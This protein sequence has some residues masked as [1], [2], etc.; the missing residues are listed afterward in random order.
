[1]GVL[2]W[3]LMNTWRTAV[4]KGETSNARLFS[5]VDMSVTELSRLRVVWLLGQCHT[6]KG[7]SPDHL[8]LC[9]YQFSGDSFLVSFQA[10]VGSVRVEDGAELSRSVYPSSH[11][12]CCRQS[13]LHSSI[14]CHHVHSPSTKVVQVSVC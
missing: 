5:L 14:S 8:S 7:I 1:M 9:G 3:R 13:L 12:V 6:D 4:K 2:A 11:L 10:A